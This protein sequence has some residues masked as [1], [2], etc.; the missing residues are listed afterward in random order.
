MWGVLGFVGL[1]K[2]VDDPRLLM[3]LPFV[4][5]EVDVGVIV[6]VVVDVA[7]VVVGCLLIMKFINARIIQTRTHTHTHMWHASN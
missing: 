4:D 3:T 6:V 2:C 1:A 7:A 5:V